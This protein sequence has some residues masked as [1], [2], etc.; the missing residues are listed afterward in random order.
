MT[1]TQLILVVFGAIA[2]FA[3]GSF[4]CV[5]IDRL[6]RRLDEE[7]KFGELWDTNTWSHVLGG[8]S[9]CS[10]CGEPIRVYD[11]IPVIAWLLLR[12]K[13]RGCGQPIPAFHLLVE[14]AA[15]VLF[16]LS[17]WALG[18]DW[19]L[20]MV[21]WLIPVGLAISVIDLRTFMV[22]TRLVWPALA[23]TLVLAVVVAAIED[24][25]MWL[26]SGVIGI[27]VLA[28]PL[29]AIWWMMPRGMGFGDVRLATLVGFNVGFFAGTNLAHA[30]FLT[31][32]ALALASTLGLV[33]GLAA[34][35]ARGRKAKV[36]FGP[37]IM[38]GGYMCMLFAAQI[39]EPFAG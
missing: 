31:V 33:L 35:G 20:L 19:R 38:L 30:A 4:T 17:V 13:C 2:F 14:L 22:P 26:A 37:T 11:N 16:L 12:G 23:V 32:I 1:T 21:G 6:P 18:A 15:P 34:M 9:R 28:G 25:W 39:L 10:S 27:I 8:S 5:V 7:N 24:E 29:F 36:P 3:L